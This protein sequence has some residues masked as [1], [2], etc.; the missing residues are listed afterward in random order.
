MKGDL[1]MYQNNS[2]FYRWENSFERDFDEAA[3][4]LYKIELNATDENMQAE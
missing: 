3:D 4:E 1:Y 2:K